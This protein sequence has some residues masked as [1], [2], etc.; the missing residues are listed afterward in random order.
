MILQPLPQMIAQQPAQAQLQL[1]QLAM[2]RAQQ[3][4]QLAMFRKQLSREPAVDAGQQAMKAAK[5]SPLW[6][7]GTPWCSRAV[8]PQEEPT[9]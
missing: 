8:Y 2:I 1:S 9:N 7:L 6:R 5:G 4:V 3:D